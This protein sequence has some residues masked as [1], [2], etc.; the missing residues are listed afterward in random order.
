MCTYAFS[1]ISSISVHN[2]SP[3]PPALYRLKSNNNFS[4]SSTQTKQELLQT[5]LQYGSSSIFIATATMGAPSRCSTNYSKLK[6]LNHT[7]TNKRLLESDRCCSMT[8][9]FLQV[10]LAWFPKCTATL[11]LLGSWHVLAHP[12]VSPGNKSDITAFGRTE[13]KSWVTVG[14]ETNGSS[15]VRV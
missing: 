8:P 11:S 7:A 15:Q 5:L 4:F 9:R 3:P 1:L 12:T 10:Y 6:G 2:V 13:V 14:F